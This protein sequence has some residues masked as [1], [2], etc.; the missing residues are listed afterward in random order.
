MAEKDMKDACGM[1]YW[2]PTDS[3]LQYLHTYCRMCIHT[4][5]QDACIPLGWTHIIRRLYSPQ[6]H[7]E[8]QS[9]HEQFITDCTKNQDYVFPEM[10][11]RCL[12]PNPYIHVSVNDLYITRIGLPIWLQQNRQNNHGNI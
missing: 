11:L 2:H 6:I 4:G 1:D 10:E 12:V 9:L 5:L 7:F 3:P 8:Q